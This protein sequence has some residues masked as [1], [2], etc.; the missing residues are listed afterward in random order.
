MSRRS[1]LIALLGLAVPV[2]ASGLQPGVDQKPEERLTLI[3][4]ARVSAVYD[5]DVS[6]SYAYALE[7][8][9]LHVLDVQ[10]PSAVHEVGVLEFEP[11][12]ARAALRHPYLYLTGFGEPMGVVDVSDPAQPR[13][14]GEW[15]ELTGTWSDVFEVADGVGYLVKQAED[16]PEGQRSL[17]LEVLDLESDPAHPRRLG[18]VDLGVRFGGEYGGIAQAD[19]RVYLVV[20]RPIDEPTPDAPTRSRLIVVDVR[21]PAEPRL[22]HNLQLPPDRLLKDVEVRGDLLYMPVSWP[23]HGL[24][25]FRLSQGGDLEPV[26]EVTDARLWRPIDLI[27]RGPAVYVTFKGDVDL[28]TFDVSD[29]TAPNISGTHTTPDLW[30]AGLG[31][32]LVEDRLY[33]AGDGG[34]TPIL[35]VS[36]PLSPRLLGYWPFKGGMVRGIVRVGNLALVANA[37]GGTFVYDVSDPSAPRRLARR[38]AATVLGIGDWQWNVVLA[39]HGSRAVVA[40]ETILAELLDLSEPTTPRVLGWHR[41]RGLVHAI[42]VT[43]THAF[44]GYRSVATGRMPDVH[45]PTSVTEGGG[46]E[47]VDIRTPRKP[48]RTAALDLGGPVTD[49]S[50]ARGYVIAALADGGLAVVDPGDP[51]EPTVLARLEGEGE[52]EALPLRTTRIATAPDG[53]RAYVAHRDLSPRGEGFA[54][55]GTL[56]VVDLRDATAPRRLGQLALAHRNEREYDIAV[57]GDQVVLFAGAVLIVDVSDPASPTVMLHEMPAPVRTW[58]ERTFLDVDDQHLYLGADEDG[59]WIYRLPDA[60]AARDR[61]SERG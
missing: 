39:A 31:M 44:L 15:P 25:V 43:E 54:Q 48:Q 14:V 10:D 34:P 51:D 27:V 46:L 11:A 55:T 24:A 13:W 16:R 8:G 5:I 6:Y 28:V 23:T 3:G 57:R 58:W 19:G 49:V 56:S 35:D 4:R 52:V 26:G 32:S 60:P 59:V 30:A 38:T 17:Q 53:A 21:E 29:P 22:L 1:V 42:A 20:E 40:Y 2:G 7:R 61:H 12:R 47:I 50:V 37:G 9:V 18:L 36:E 45:D 33:V 41:P